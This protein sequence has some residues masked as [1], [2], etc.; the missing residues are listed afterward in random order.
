MGGVYFVEAPAELLVTLTLT[1]ILV[2]FSFRV[3]RYPE[4]PENL[5]VWERT[6]VG[7][8]RR[9]RGGEKRRKRG[10]GEEGVEERRAMERKMHG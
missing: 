7:K 2:V 5:P 8:G 10:K 1:L 6:E 4:S 3:R 9:E